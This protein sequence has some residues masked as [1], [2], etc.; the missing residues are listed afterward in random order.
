MW[1]SRV[2]FYLRQNEDYS[3]GRAFQV[4]LRNF[5]KEVG[6]KVSTCVI[7][8]KRQRS[9]QSSRHFLQKVTGITKSRHQLNDF[10]ALKG[11]LKVSSCSSSWFN[12]CKSRW[13]VA[14]LSWHFSKPTSRSNTQEQPQEGFVWET[15]LICFWVGIGKEELLL[16][17][18]LIL[19]RGWRKGWV[20][21][22]KW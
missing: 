13:Q 11:M 18:T 2:R 20:F 15:M 8:V 10:S 4:A 17:S 1:E 5:S 16:R 12:P 21:P 9:M 19:H 22:H 14:T 6:G 3:S 7:L